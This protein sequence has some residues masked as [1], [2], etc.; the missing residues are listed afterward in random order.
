[1][2]SVL[3]NE[4]VFKKF[5]EIILPTNKNVNK[6]QWRISY[7]T[8]KRYNLTVTW[9]RSVQSSIVKWVLTAVKAAVLCR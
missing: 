5:R 8:N 7:A 2:I 6:Y 3:H 9:T 4:A 1:M